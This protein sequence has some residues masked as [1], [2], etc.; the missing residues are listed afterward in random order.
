MQEL[1]VFG[2]ESSIAELIFQLENTFSILAIVLVILIML[3]KDAMRHT[4][5]P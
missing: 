5:E 2:S 3:A 4:H 1:V